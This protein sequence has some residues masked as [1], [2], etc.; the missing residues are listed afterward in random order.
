MMAAWGTKAL[1]SPARS[2][3]TAAADTAIS[4]S[5]TTEPLPFPFTDQSFDPTDKDGVGGLLLNNPSNVADSVK[6]NPRTNEYEF[7]Q[8]IGKQDYRYPSTMTL[9]EYMDYDMEKT[10]RKNWKARSTADSKNKV[11]DLNK[12]TPK[13]H[14][15]AKGEI[16]NRIFGGDAVDI[17]P[18][19]SA[20][21]IFGWN[22]NKNKNPNISVDNQKNSYFD[23]SQKI[24]LNLLGKIGDKMKITT[25]YNTEATFDF[26]NQVKLEYTGYEDEIIKKIEAGNV[27]LPLTGTLIT[28]SQSLFG[29]KTQLQFGKLTATAIFSQQKGQKKEITSKGGAQTTP[30]EINGDNYEA[31]KHFFL[32]QYFRDQYDIALASLPLINSNINITQIEVWVTN[33]T[34]NYDQARDIVAFADLGESNRAVGDNKTWYA[35]SFIQG[36]NPAN[37]SGDYPDN[38]GSNNLYEKIT[39][40]SQL[41]SIATALNA[42]APFNNGVTKYAPVQD[43]EKINNARKLSPND[44]TL[45]PR[46]GYISLNQPLT[47]GEV[48]GVSYQYTIG[49]KTYT[50]GEFSNEVS[51]P[52]TLFLKMLKASNVRVKLPIWDLMMKNVYS[53]GGYGISQT[54][55]KL[56]ITHSNLER[57]VDLNFIPEGAV[58]GKILLQV[59]G[60]DK[61]DNQSFLNPDGIFDFVPDITISA[62]NGRIYF[63]VIEPFGK[64]LRKQFTFDQQGIADKYVFQELYDST[65]TQAQQIPTKN[66]F[67]LKGSYKSTSGSEISL[68]SVNIPQGSVTVTANGVPL[69]E[70]VDYTVDYVSGKVKVIN[71][72][73]LVSQTPIKASFETNQ[74]FSIQTKSLFGTHLEYKVNKDFVL[75]GTLLHLKERP[76]TQKI[77]VGD[78]PISNTIFGFDGTYRTEVPFLTRMVDRIPL[79]NTK[80]K[81][82]IAIAGEYAQI[83]PGHSKAIGKTGTSYVDDF[84]GSQSALDFK[85]VSAWSIASTPQGQTEPGAFPEGE[86]VDSTLNGIN[87]AKL[88]FYVIDPLFFRDSQFTPA[89]IKNN[90][91]E[92]SDHRVREVL[93]TEIF[94]NKQ[95]INNQIVNLPLLDLAYYPTERGPYNYDASNTTV[96]AGLNADGSLKSPESRWAGMMRKIDNND[97]ESS[98]IEFIQFWMMDPFN[99]DNT[100]PNSTGDLYFNL[101]D[102][103]EDILHDGQKSFENGLPADG[104]IN[105]L[106]IDSTKLALVPS[107]S[108]PSVVNAFD[109][110]P[111][112]RVFQDVGLDGLSDNDERGFF[113][114]YLNRVSTL[115]GASSGAYINANNDPS[116]DDYSYFRGPN[117]DANST[118]ILERYKFYNGLEGNSTLTTLDNGPTS[119]TSL[120]NIEDINRD[121]NLIQFENYFQYR[122]KLTP[123]SMNVGQNYITDM[124]TSTVTTKN[125]LSRSVKWYQFKVP[126]RSPERVI[127]EPDIRNIRSVR[128]FLKGFDKPIVCRFARLEFLRGDWRKYDLGKLS[129]EYEP[130]DNGNAL[131]NI[132]SVN[133]EENSNRIP[134]NYKI[135]PTIQRET[136]VT[137]T[138]NRQLNEQS[139]VLDVCNLEDGN[140]K[141]A[142]K[143]VDLDV[144]QYKKM[145]LFLHEEAGNSFEALN[146]GDLHFFI[147]LGTDFNDNYYEYDVPMTP[148]GWGDNDEYN[149]WQTTSDLNGPNDVNIEF[150]ALQDAKKSRNTLINTGQLDPSLSKIYI[151]NDGNR[152]ISIKGNPNLSAV[153]VIMIGIRNPKHQT[154]NDGDD[155]LAKC[156]EIWVNELRLTDFNEKGGWAANARV[157]AKLADFANVSVA[158]SRMT[159]GF[160]NIEQKL[161]ERSRENTFQYD[162]S[163]EVKLDKFIPEKVG[164]SIPM[165]VGYSQAFINPQYNPLDP[166]IKF[167]ESL[168]TYTKGDQ[169]DSVKKITQDYTERRSLNFANIK[170]ERKG[171]GK[172]GKPKKPMPYD[173]ENISLRYSYNDQFKRDIRTEKN[174][175]RSTNGGLTYV[176]TTQPK[177]IKPF[178]KSNALKSDYFKLIKDFNFNLIPSSFQFTTDLKRDYT[179]QKLRAVNPAYAALPATYFKKF[180][181]NRVYALKYDLSKS[182]SIDY[183]ANNIARVDELPGRAYKEYDKETEQAQR[184]SIRKPILDNLKKLGTTTNYNQSTKVTWQV[185]INKFPL[186]NWTTVTASYTGNYDWMIAPPFANDTLNIGNTIS[187]SNQIQINADANMVTLYNKVPY[188]KKINSPPPKKDK[189]KEVKREKPDEK[190]KEAPKEGEKGATPDAGTQAADSSKKEKGQSFDILKSI[191]KVVMM[192]K[193]VSGTYTQTN[194]TL[195]PG[196]LPKTTLFGLSDQS[197]FG[198]YEAPGVGFVFGL[199][200]PNYALKAADKGWLSKSK[201]LNSNY[202]RTYSEVINF[203]S[204]VEPFKDFRIVLNATRN[205]TRSNSAIVKFDSTLVSAQSSG[206]Y[207][208][209]PLETG[210]FS[211]SV[212]SFGTAFK[213]NRSNYSSPVFDEFLA[214]RKEFSQSVS[215]G[216][217]SNGTTPEGYAD[218]YGQYSQDVL[219]PAFVQAYTNSKA[220]NTNK[221]FKAIPRL[222]WRVNYDGLSKLE[223]VKKYFKTLSLGHTYRSTLNIGSYT[224]NPLFLDEDGF[225]H[226]TV[227]NIDGDFRSRKEINSITLSE[228]FSPLISVD[229]TWNNSL[230]TKAEIK[231]DRLVTLTISTKQ[232]TEVN[233]NEYIFGLGYRFKNV[234]INLKQFNMKFKSDLA[235]RSDVSYRRNQ[236]ALRYVDTGASILTSGQKVWSIKNSADY[237]INEKLNIRFFY[238]QTI[239]RPV[240]STSFP[241]SNRQIGISLRL[242][243]AN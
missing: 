112:A 11:E 143:N 152:T 117:L 41:R 88:S 79:I 61:I 180:G 121:N 75:G 196:Y 123:S 32:S 187:N 182:I 118:P 214:S 39:G 212:N 239:N 202:T 99:E 135:P 93:E 10:L 5:D 115:F 241:T 217:F 2:K 124:R 81:S 84:E 222:N 53:I 40:L 69:T 233:G 25:N 162:A 3:F 54:D 169:R 91:G 103:S 64:Y 159:E 108:N 55:F 42:L 209:S 71:D 51:R 183:L 113:S 195:L 199:Q 225:G 186:L 34:G 128:M 240:V 203:T 44:Y 206:F 174:F 227:R 192:V 220:K 234:S 161:N 138:N 90:P 235:L 83:V 179:E 28:G 139:L 67:K 200:D 57:G 216:T 150:S 22:T 168:D 109:N 72:A 48:L 36:P 122:V 140:S 171:G 8:T 215:E 219:I 125:G 107:P 188:F 184:D 147:R 137:T 105:P 62:K 27:S 43:Y 1:V 197:E 142:Y 76:I 4:L 65:K 156:A 160:G 85:S 177:S 110:N 68:N 116:A 20:E 31:N 7:H 145:K 201:Y 56:D 127:G 205:I 213:K 119:S 58:N 194:G 70:N 164:L 94:P 37:A 158:A 19:G 176:Y 204:N 175:S 66:R 9:E 24:Q 89:H 151:S 163:A 46:L 228:Q 6:F 114:N 77:N 242:T 189:K 47:N 155:G 29:V 52:S 129:G 13:L 148:T 170:K 35:Q 86:I 165:Y 134:I 23:F 60:L 59:V 106:L 63:P 157:T 136:D 98:N 38:K 96:S 100:S 243:I 232:V 237:I 111:T 166:D 149:I 173:I 78:E 17:R 16:F 132:S 49:T 146:F 26:E 131:F 208:Q 33:T 223:V 102:I 45:N 74:L 126:V 120:P 50:V 133:V 14:F 231:K 80:E 101:G 153:K 238:D 198:S 21:L 130:I 230:L 229:M 193:K 224:W 87:R 95:P 178:A 181:F 207:Q 218:G 185:P 141:A 226:T 82:S 236:T 12:P 211:I 167:N 210:T 221:V 104:I 97:F 18:Q 15:K 154:Q 92:R 30:F 144:R 172:G 190:A 191:A 73:L